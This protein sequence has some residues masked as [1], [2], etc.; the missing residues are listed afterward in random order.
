MKKFS[1][2]LLAL[3]MMFSAVPMNTAYAAET[4]AVAASAEDPASQIGINDIAGKWNYQVSSGN[5]AVEEGAKDNGTVEIKADGTYSYTDTNGKV[6]TGTVKIGIDEVGGTKFTTVLF[7]NGTEVSFAGYYRGAY[8]ISIG[9]GG[10]ARLVREAEPSVKINDIVGKWW[11]EIANVTFENG[12]KSNGTI[13]IKADGTYSHTDANGK[14]TTGTVKIGAEVIEGTKID[15]VFFNDGTK[16]GFGGYLRKLNDV[17]MISIGNG[18]TA[19][20][21]RQPEVTIGVKDVVGKWDYQVSDGTTTVDKLAK[22]NGTI[23]I[24]AD[25]TYSYTDLNGKVTTGTIK[26][27]YEMIEYSVFDTVSFI[28][29]TGKRFTGGIYRKESQEISLGNGGQG[30]LVRSADTTI[31]SGDANCDNSVDLSDA[32]LIMQSISNPSKYGVKG[33]DKNKITE[34]GNINADCSSTGDGVTNADA[35]AIQKYKLAIITSLPEKK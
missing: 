23:E 8:E 1:A 26:L 35:L 30:R 3:G 27:D 2:Y 21:I 16:D 29:S 25:G 10:M 33:T 7:S 32:V 12:A 13:E 19:R 20:L 17:K 11:Y 15:T 18:D 24:K 14:V 5:Y 9:N 34:Q 22:P 31:L 4:T 6:T 28:D